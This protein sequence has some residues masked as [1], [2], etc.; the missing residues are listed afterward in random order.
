MKKAL[1]AIALTLIISLLC[2][3]FVACSGKSQNGDPVYD[4]DYSLVLSDYLEA[5]DAAN[6]AS[7]ETKR[8]GAKEEIDPVD[9]SAIYDD[10][11]NGDLTITEAIA[12]MVDGATK[13]EIVCDHF[14]YFTNKIGS[15][16]LGGNEGSLVYQRLRKQT[17]SVKD[18]TTI[19]LPINHNFNSVASTFVTSA[20]IRYISSE[21]KYY[22]MNNKSDIIYNFKTGI[23]EVEKWK[24][25]SA[26]NW[27]DSQLAIWS[28]S[29]E[30]ARKTPINWETAGIVAKDGAELEYNE[31]GGY[32]E[33]TFSIDIKVAN[34]DKSGKNSTIKVLE[35][36][37]GGSNMKYEY[38][39][40][41]VQIWECGLAKRYDIDESWSGKIQMY[42]GSAQNKQVTVF[43]YSEKDC[44]DYSITQAHYNSIAKK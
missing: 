16:K 5:P 14:A 7:I 24:K 17:D 3:S 31:D 41:K 28:R 33:L 2:V 42:S 12:Q 1:S 10:Y 35:N 8:D 11:M 19:K 25:Q 43:S 38:C 39:K 21:G 27:N 44:L 9:V 15:T 20:D 36:D 32:Y 4:V 22:R 13:N 26:K 30:E 37:N 29:I 40:F 34:N 6:V 18:D 23:L